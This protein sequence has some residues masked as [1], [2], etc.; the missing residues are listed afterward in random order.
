MENGRQ[1]KLSNELFQAPEIMFN[2]THLAYS[3]NNFMFPRKKKFNGIHNLI[4]ETINSCDLTMKKELIRT[5]VFVGG[6]TCYPGFVERT[7]N[8]IKKMTHMKVFG[9]AEFIRKG[10][11]IP[12]TPVT[13]VFC[14]GCVLANLSKDKP[15]FW[16]SLDGYKELG[17]SKLI[18]TF[19]V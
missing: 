6:N 18:D 11:E 7:I 16:M 3:P 10:A 19:F 9:E 12:S 15:N 1:I 14:G 5:I 17:S 2:E 13:S 4:F 8:G